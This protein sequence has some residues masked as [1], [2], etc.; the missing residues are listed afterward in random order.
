MPLWSDL[1]EPTRAE[2][3][4]VFGGRS[5]YVPLPPCVPD[6]AV[7][8]YVNRAEIAGYSQRKACRLAAEWCHKHPD[9][10][11]RILARARQTRQ[12]P[13]CCAPGVDPE[14]GHGSDDDR[15]S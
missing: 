2:M 11:W 3:I 9:T 6:E 1:S 15:A 14:F 13:R 5:I 8:A 4:R 10:V 12:E 7:I